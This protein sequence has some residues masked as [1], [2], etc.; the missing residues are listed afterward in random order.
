LYLWPLLLA[1]FAIRLITQVTVLVLIQKKLNE[2]G[3]LPFLQIFDIL[4]PFINAVIYIGSLRQGA[5]R[6]KWN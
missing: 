6:Y 4:S 2:E 5:G 1:V 3:L